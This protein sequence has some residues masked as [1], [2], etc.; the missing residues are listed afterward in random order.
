MARQTLKERAAAKAA[1]FLSGSQ[2]PDSMD[3]DDEPV[4][5]LVRDN[6]L[7]L[8]DELKFYEAEDL[9]ENPLND[10]PALPDDEFEELVVDILRKGVIIATII[11]PDIML[12]AGQNRRRATIEANKRIAKLKKKDLKALKLLEIPPHR[13]I[14]CVTVLS[15]L[16]EETEKGLMESE[17]ERRRG[18]R[19]SVEKMRGYIEA[20]FQEELEKDR[21]GGSRGN[22]HTGGQDAKS[23]KEPLAKEISRKSRGNIPVSTAKKIT[24][25]IKKKNKTPKKTN[26]SKTNSDKNV[27]SP[28][29]LFGKE[30]KKNSRNPCV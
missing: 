29:K 11:K 6:G 21:R 12:I 28:E 23:S 16:D 20:N 25:D 22:Q 17:N 26:V 2:R 10:Y 3:I 13:K 8:S 27:F 15:K 9:I 1:T 19:W 5:K 14:P 24:A 4:R 18:G 7:L 30:L